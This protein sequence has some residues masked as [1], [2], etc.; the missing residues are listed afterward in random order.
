MSCSS[1]QLRDPFLTTADLDSG[2]L[3]VSWTTSHACPEE[4]VLS[5]DC[6]V[7]APGGLRADLTALDLS[8]RGQYYNVTVPDGLDTYSYLLSPCGSPLPPEVSALYVCCVQ[9]ATHI[10]PV[11][12]CKP[13]PNFLRGFVGKF[14]VSYIPLGGKM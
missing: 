5:R 9:F 11:S 14:F 10:L 13:K 3:V 1:I 4:H 12:D 6:H 7:T 8:P 2:S